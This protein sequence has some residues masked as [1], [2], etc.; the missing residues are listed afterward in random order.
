MPLRTY[1][2]SLNEKFNLKHIAADYKRMSL[3]DPQVYE[4]AQKEKRLIITYN[5]KDF[6]GLIK[7]NAHTGIIGIS[8]NLTLSQIDKKLTALLL[9]A[10]KNEL[11]GKVTKI[12]GES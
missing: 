2:P 11:Q 1:F 9:K 7:H 10:T 4:F 8:A 6:V 12:T 3:P 5:V